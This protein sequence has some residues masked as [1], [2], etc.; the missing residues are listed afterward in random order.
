VSWNSK[1]SVGAIGLIGLTVAGVAG[2][3]TR[4]DKSAGRW[5]LGGFPNCNGVAIVGRPSCSSIGYRKSGRPPARL[6]LVHALGRRTIRT[7]Y[8]RVAVLRSRAGAATPSNTARSGG[9][10]L[11]NRQQQSRAFTARNPG[12]SRADSAPM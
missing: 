11:P 4:S 3:S 10:D 2:L 1:W 8:A 9:N 12:R 7:R 5:M 6:M